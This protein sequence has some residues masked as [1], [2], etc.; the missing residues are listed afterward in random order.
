MA[1]NVATAIGC[2]Y[3]SPDAGER[4]RIFDEEAVVKVVGAETGG[5]YALVTFS[6]APGGG[7]P[8]HAHPGNETAYVLSGEFAFT[9][10]DASGI[11]TFR[12]GPGAVAHAPGGAAH[13]FENVGP[14]RGMMVQILSPELVDFLRELGAAFP[15]G[16]EPD[17]ERM[18]AINAKYGNELIYGGEG[19]R[20]EPAKEDATSE[21]ARALAW[22]FAQA[23]D[24]LIA[25]I[26]RC[27]PE[28]WRATCADT[29]W[30][31]GVQAHHI[32]VGELPIA[33]MI[34]A[35]AAGEPPPPMPPGM[36]DAINARHAAE[37]ANVTKEEAVALLR[38]NGA[39]AAETYRT[40]T[41]AQLAR[42]TAPTAGEHPA[43][44][45]QLIEYLAIGEI[46]RHGAA[47]RAAIGA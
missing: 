9:Q 12:A 40:L 15:P 21:R 3:V 28:Q 37:F 42:T 2:S 24:A 33:A 30:T 31:V 26:E 10:R 6:V 23:N 17:M 34:R 19:S 27:T 47:L 46:E 35:V 32:A 8:L 16:A 36:L 43:S 22:R 7:P 4:I 18:L 14:T 1:T 41:D 38:E 29:G 45:A 13:R 20:P 25:T 44:V 11:S 39:R 5:A